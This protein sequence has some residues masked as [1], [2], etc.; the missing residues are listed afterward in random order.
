MGTRRK[1][2]KYLSIIVLCT[3]LGAGTALSGD[4]AEVKARGVLRH[5]GV[6]YANFVTGAGDGLSVE[7]MQLFAAHL[8]VQYQYVKT[9][10]SDVI[11]DLVGKEVRPEGDNVTLGKGRP[12]SGD[13]I[14][15]GL[16]ILPWRQKVVAFSAPTF[17]TQVWLISRAG[18]GLKPITPSGDI[19]NDIA[20]TKAIV[21]QKSLLGKAGTC[22]DPSLYH[23]EEAGARTSAHPGNLNE[24]AP[25]VINRISDTAILDVPDTLV[26]LGKWP[27]QILVLGPISEQQEMAVA[28]RPD[29]TGLLREFNVFFGQIRHDGRYKKLVEKYYPAVFDYYPEYFA[30]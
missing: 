1:T 16:T 24:L 19:N 25:A 15:N 26:A 30:Q 2:M 11:P 7:L 20:A 27:G 22:L 23:L 8:G 4:L 29:D 18:S 6:P 28:F 13:V 17:P 21:A 12:I 5:L 3:W 9:T 10:W 14:A